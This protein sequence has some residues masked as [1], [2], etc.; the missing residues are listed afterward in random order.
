MPPFARI[1]EPI[2]RY[3]TQKLLTH[4]PTAAGVDWNSAESQRLRFQHLL[5]LFDTSRPFTINDYGCGYGALVDHLTERGLSFQYCGCD[6]SAAMIEHGRRAHAGR[7]DCLFVREESELPIADYS[8]A[9]G[10]L[11]VKL[12]AT[13]EEWH[14]YVHAALERLAGLSTRGFACN[15]LTSHGDPER[16]EP[17]LFYAD[18]TQIFDYCRRR[19]P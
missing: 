17:R 9:S 12:A 7:G 5:R 19:F 1:V 2:E 13:D 14:R 16:R 8:V 15:F 10:V 4:G 3:Y 18:P 6:I 11:N